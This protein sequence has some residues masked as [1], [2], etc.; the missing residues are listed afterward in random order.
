M[1][2]PMR[3]VAVVNRHRAPRQGHAKCPRL[4]RMQI[5][6]SDLALIKAKTRETL[7]ERHENRREM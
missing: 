4:A 2:L 6:P 3:S 1:C 7:G 5:S